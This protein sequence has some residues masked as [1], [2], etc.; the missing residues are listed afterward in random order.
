MRVEEV[1]FQHRGKTVTGEVVF[2]DTLEEAIEMLGRDEV[3]EAFAI[4]YLERQKKRLRRNPRKTLRI[5]L[6]Q[7]TEEQREAF[8]R[9]GFLKD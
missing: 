7:I 4:G 2:P 1:N 5:K 6:D 3:F 9:L 8:K